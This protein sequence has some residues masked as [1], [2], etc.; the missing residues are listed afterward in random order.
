MNPSRLIS[1]FI[2]KRLRVTISKK[3]ILKPLQMVQEIIFHDQHY[4]TMQPKITSIFLDELGVPRR[5]A[6]GSLL[7][8]AAAAHTPALP[9]Y[10]WAQP[11]PVRQQQLAESAPRACVLYSDYEGAQ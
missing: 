10:Y 11:T 6:L 2:R 8:T 4:M 5:F 9:T 3:S 7:K 1:V